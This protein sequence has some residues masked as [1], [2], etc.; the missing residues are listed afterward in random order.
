M[1]TAGKETTTRT[2]N[3]MD[4]QRAQSHGPFTA[5]YCLVSLFLGYWAIVFWD[6]CGGPEKG[7]LDLSEKE[8]TDLA[9][10][11]LAPG[12]QAAYLDAQGT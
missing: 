8:A 6:A 12:L 1:R 10:R 2:Q 11:G 9:A 3:S 4:L 5:K 7:A